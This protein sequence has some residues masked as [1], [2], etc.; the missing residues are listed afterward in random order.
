MVRK[1]IT[2]RYKVVLGPAQSN[3]RG[4][5]WEGDGTSSVGSPTK[6]YRGIY[7]QDPI[8]PNGQTGTLPATG[9]QD[10]W[11]PKCFQAVYDATGIMTDLG[12]TAV[13]GTSVV[14]HWC[15][16]PSGLGTGTPYAMADGGFDPNGYFADALAEAQ[17]G[18]FD[19][20]YVIMSLGQTDSSLNVT[21]VNY[22]LGLQNAI[23]YFE[24]NGVTVI[25]GF[26]CFQTGDATWYSTVGTVAIANLLAAN[27]SVLAGANLYDLWGERLPLLADG[28]RGGR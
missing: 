7:Q 27:P 1:D 23:D 3:E 21:L 15:G 9:N 4:H 6:A 16:D 14:K 10:S 19:A 5:R 2:A 24:A 11:W 12:N 20:R 26:T 8:L 25:L 18:T 28:A 17:K 22:Q 13:G